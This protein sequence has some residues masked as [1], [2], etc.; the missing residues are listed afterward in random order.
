MVTM[1]GRSV[2]GTTSTLDTLDTLD[3]LELEATKLA[4]HAEAHLRSSRT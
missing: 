1:T 3:T 4:E 2:F